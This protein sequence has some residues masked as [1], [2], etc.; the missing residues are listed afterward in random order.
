M[1]GKAINIYVGNLPLEMTEDELRKEFQIFGE[2]ASVT[3]IDDEY[4]GSS[5]HK[6]YGYV[7]MA[8]KSEGETAIDNLEGKMMKGMP[9]SV[10]KALPLS[11]KHEPGSTNTKSGRRFYKERGRR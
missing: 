7:E 4:A 1:N 9:V 2:V 11:N 3:I 8:V 6:R 5:Q 10:I